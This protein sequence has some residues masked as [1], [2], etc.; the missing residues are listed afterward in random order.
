M[1]AFYKEKS[2]LLQRPLE[3][4]STVASQLV[5]LSGLYS[6]N[7]QIDRHSSAY[8]QMHNHVAK[9]PQGQNKEA[10]S[11]LRHIGGSRPRLLEFP[12]VPIISGATI[13]LGR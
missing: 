3:S 7:L 1:A 4:P 12:A 9:E 11:E 10:L 8:V 2:F 5:C 13:P 6:S